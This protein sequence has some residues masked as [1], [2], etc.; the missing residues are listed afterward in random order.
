V[1]SI[2]QRIPARWGKLNRYRVPSSA[3]KL[4]TGIACFLAVLFFMVI[5]YIGVLSGPPAHLAASFY[6][7][8]V[9]T[10]TILWAFATCFLF[11]NLLVLLVRRGGIVRQHLIA[12][13]WILSLS[14]VFGLLVGVVAIVDTV[15]NSYDPPDI[16]NAV[17]WYLVLG[18][19]VCVLVLGAISGLLANSEADWQGMGAGNNQSTPL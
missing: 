10:A 12:P 5:P 14:S 6:F 1:A 15:L 4:Q 7:V 8:L 11:I 17:W 16:A 9:G 13:S 2:D 18:L 3:I 19:T